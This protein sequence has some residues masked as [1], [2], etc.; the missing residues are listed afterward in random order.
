MSAA[1]SGVDPVFSYRT[2]PVPAHWP[3]L[4]APYV[5]RTHPAGW[6][7]LAEPLHGTGAFVDA[8]LATVPASAAS[9]L[10][11]RLGQTLSDRDTAALTG[12]SRQRVRLTEQDA[13]RRTRPR[14]SLAATFL[15]EHLHADAR[16]YD[17]SAS[18]SARLPDATPDD[19]WTLALALCNA[20]LPPRPGAA[21]PDARSTAAVLRARALGE[22]RWHFSG[23]AATTSD[24]SGVAATVQAAD[25]FV[26]PADQDADPFSLALAAADPQVAELLGLPDLLVTTGGFLAG[27]RW[28]L[29]QW[30]TALATVLHDQGQ[31]EWHYSQ[32]EW[33]LNFVFP[34]EFGVSRSFHHAR[35]PLYTS[36]LFDA[37]GRNGYWRLKAY[38]DG[39]SSNPEVIAAVMARIPLPM[40][41]GEIHAEALKIRTLT[42]EVVWSYL[43]SGRYYQVRRGRYWLTGR[44]VPDVRPEEQVMERLFRASGTTRLSDQQVR[45]DFARLIRPG[46]TPDRLRQVGQFSRHY[47]WS[48]R[49]ASPGNAGYFIA[50]TLGGTPVTSRTPKPGP[51]PALRFWR[52]CWRE[53]SPLT[54]QQRGAGLHIVRAS[55]AELIRHR[56]LRRGWA[57]TADTL[58]AP[59]APTPNPGA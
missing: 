52:S 40:S 13:L 27:R 56:Y 10:W 36:D 23:T 28:P 43:Y 33:A 34:E 2:V 14:A 18:V 8:Y 35:G 39:F 1:S 19:L 50:L 15:A 24:L 30:V 21:S 44:P 6:T 31:T 47:R 9:V 41:A 55:G 37:A 59:A 12:V 7:H 51:A 22:H 57:W 49:Q 20:A 58:P 16:L 32:I 45:Q 17:V 42:L 48:A 5:V 29:T 3:H 53:V 25:T 54:A 46:T 38:G 26:S 4:L 11:H